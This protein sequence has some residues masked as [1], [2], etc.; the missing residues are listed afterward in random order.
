MTNHTN[1]LIKIIRNKKTDFFDIYN[2][3]K[4][5]IIA[6]FS[7]MNMHYK[8]YENNSDFYLCYYVLLHSYQ[9]N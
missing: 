4:I 6:N 2:K 7:I 8:V 9:N 5:Y 3:K 1:I